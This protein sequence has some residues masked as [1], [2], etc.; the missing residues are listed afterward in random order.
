MEENTDCVFDLTGGEELYLVVVGMIAERYSN[1]HIQ[2]HRFNLR[3]DKLYDCDMDGVTIERPNELQLTVRENIQ[4]YGGDIIDYDAEKKPDGTYPW[5]MNEEF[6]NDIRAM[7]NFCKKD[8]HLWNTQIGVIAA[9]NSLSM[10]FSEDDP[11]TVTALMPEL[12]DELKKRKGKLHFSEALLDA[13]FDNDL[14][15]G[16][17]YDE[18]YFSIT[19]KNEQVKRCLT[20]AGQVLEML[21]YITAL[22][23]EENSER[24]YNDVMTGVCID[25][26]GAIHE[27]GEAP[28]TVNEIDVIMMHGMIPVF[29]SCKNGAVDMD[30][31]YKLNTVAERFGG[32]YAKK[33][34]VATALPST[35]AF[36]KQFRQRAA[37]MQIHLINHIQEMTDTTLNKT[38]CDRWKS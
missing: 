26:D 18:E 36:G 27:N 11:L 9:A 31:L 10:G 35:T 24:V 1:K 3:N 19:F 17:S 37:D 12:A 14:L 16:F 32:K 33:V 23:A 34:L 7:W 21:I 38:I 13:L 29:V 22:H 15:T 4:I 20:K 28:D 6:C 5:D 2:M 8:V 25:W 30:E